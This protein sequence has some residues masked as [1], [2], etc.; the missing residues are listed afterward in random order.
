M[1]YSLFIDET[2]NTGEP[3]YKNGKWNWGI[4]QYFALGAILMR[5]D[6]TDNLLNELSEVLHRMDPKLGTVNEWKSTANYRFNKRLMKEVLC[7]LKKY[8]VYHYIDITNK[9]YKLVNY[10]VDYCVYPYYL[11]ESDLLTHPF[12]YYVW[13]DKKI[14]ISNILYYAI[15]DDIDNY[16]WKFVRICHS[17]VNDETYN[18]FCDFL[19][20]FNIWLKNRIGLDISNTVIQHVLDYKN[21][22]L[23]L[24]NIFPLND[25]SDTG[26]QICFTPNIDAFNNIVKRALNKDYY[27]LDEKISIRIIHDEQKEFEPAIRKWTD[28]INYHGE[29]Y[30]DNITFCNSQGSL[31]QLVDFIVGRMCRIFDAIV[32]R[33][34]TKNSDNELIE[35]VKPLII[36]NVNVVAPQK[37]QDFFFSSFGLKT[38]KTEIF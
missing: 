32:N 14:A 25:S 7:L 11:F 12:N 37:E 5:T 38:V 10:L 4:D 26:K 6:E 3:R 28:A 17:D 1:N 16:L 2:G 24:K 22:D 33:K 34:K 21:F 31:I 9:R 8:D 27:S 36:N 30:I 23:Q 13:R 20:A 15:N 29:I 19:K 35:I 18:E